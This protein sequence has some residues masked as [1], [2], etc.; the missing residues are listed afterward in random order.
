MKK[1]CWV[2]F[3]TLESQGGAHYSPF[4]STRYRVLIPA[5][6]LSQRGYSQTFVSAEQFEVAI[7]AVKQADIVVFSKSNQQSNEVLMEAAQEA[8]AKVWMDMCDYKL[9]SPLRDHYLNML[10]RVDGVVTNTPELATAILV[11]TGRQANVVGDPYEGP[12]GQAEWK[13]RPGRRIEALWFGHPSNLDTLLNLLRQLVAGKSEVALSVRICT[14]NRPELESDCRAFNR[15]F[16]NRLKLFFVPWSVEQVWRELAGTDLVLIPSRVGLDRKNVKSPNRLV[17]S[18]WGG[19]FVLAS[20]LPAYLEFGEWMGLVEDFRAGIDWVLSHQSELVP[21]IRAAQVYI[22]AHYSP[23][24][25]GREW[26]KVI[27]A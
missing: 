11:E 13:W 15:E 6:W 2:T 19:R 22:A 27:E 26:E 9:D 17:E 12:K 5:R 21:R 3:S 14:Q 16:G 7:E 10:S 4:A 1:I 20:P 24:V 25:I 23:E 18:V 8:G